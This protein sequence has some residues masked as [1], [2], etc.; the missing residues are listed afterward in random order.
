MLFFVY[1]FPCFEFAHMG[2]ISGFLFPKLPRYA[3]GGTLLPLA[4]LTTRV[5]SHIRHK[6]GP[7]AALPE[8][9]LELFFLSPVVSLS[10]VA[11]AAMGNL[12]RHKRRHYDFSSSSPCPI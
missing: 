12:H 7:S 8:L 6:Q 4:A 3:I 5:S 9:E 2:T 11:A 10:L 1:L